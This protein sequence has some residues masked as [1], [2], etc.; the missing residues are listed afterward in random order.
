MVPLPNIPDAGATNNFQQ[1]IGYHQVA[2]QFDAKFDQALGARDHFAYRFSWQQINT[3]QQPSFGLAGGPE[4]FEGTGAENVFNT[5]GEYTHVLSPSFLTEV[6]VGVDHD[7]N[8]TYPSD[9]GSDASSQLG[10]P[11]VNVSPFTS[12]LT[13]ISIS[14]YSSP[15]VGCS[16]YEPW[17]RSETNIDVLNNWT[18]IAGNHSLKFGFEMRGNRQDLVQSTADSP[19]GTFDYGTGQTSLNASGVSAGYANA[20][21][22]FLL[23]VPSSVSRQ[24]NIGDSSWR[25]QLYYA[26][27]Q[28]TWQISHKLTLIYGMRMG[29][30][31]AA[32]PKKAGG[33]SQYNPTNNSLE[34]AGWKHPFQPGCWC[35]CRF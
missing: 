11:G 31:P 32:T 12:G 18:K 24:D 30:I 25:E 20:F 3:L 26:F 28:D 17:I 8:Y 10:I 15:L 19:R 5:A 33:F 1:N 34:V 35:P 29:V 7:S 27:A 14:D 9:Y 23:D 6:R 21:A 22:S 16:P 4:N 13:T 2:N